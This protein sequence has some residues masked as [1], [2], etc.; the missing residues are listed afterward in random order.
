MRRI[1]AKAGC[2]AMAMYRHFENKEELLFSICE[3]TFSEMVRRIDAG[4]EKPGT[5]LE[6]LRRCV[7]TIIDFHLNHPKPVQSYVHDRDTAG[8]GGRAAA[9][10]GAAR[11]GPPAY[12]RPRSRRGRGKKRST[13]KSSR[14]SSASACTA[15]FRTLIVT[16]KV[17]PWKD[18]EKLKNELIATVTRIL[19]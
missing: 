3:E 4:R 7:R 14:T 2:S 15:W 10:P 19:E 9:G 17:Y 6:K 13:W 16:G 18:V 8:T 12:R 5:R 11:A 1:G